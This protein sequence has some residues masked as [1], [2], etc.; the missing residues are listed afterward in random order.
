MTKKLGA[1]PVTLLK[2][3]G[4]KG[5]K[6]KVSVKKITITTAGLKI[7][8]LFKFGKTGR[9]IEK[10]VIPH[11]ATS[12]ALLNLHLP[13]CLLQSTGGSFE[14]DGDFTGAM[15]GPDTLALAANGQLTC[16]AT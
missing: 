12:L 9:R 11:C 7:G 15:L 3:N 14:K 5:K 2:I 16:E 6:K 1:I 13:R 8:V 10:P 4:I